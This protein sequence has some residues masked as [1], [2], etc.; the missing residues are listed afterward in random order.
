MDPAGPGT[1]GPG[2]DLG[3]TRPSPCCPWASASP[4]PQWLLEHTCPPVSVHSADGT[5]PGLGAQGCSGS[6]VWSRCVLTTGKTWGSQCSMPTSGPLPPGRGIGPRLAGH[7][8]SAGRGRHGHLSGFS[9]DVGRGQWTSPQPPPPT[10]TPPQTQPPAP[11]TGGREAA[12]SRALQ[13]HK[14]GTDGAGPWGQ[15]GCPEVTTSDL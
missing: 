5:G 8:Y 4:T 6:A 2:E 7:R 13:L 1:R 15:G 3:E 10:S 9:R 12:L 14:V 11:G